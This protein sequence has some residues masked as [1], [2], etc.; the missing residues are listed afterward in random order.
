VNSVEY[1][2]QRRS[3]LVVRPARRFDITACVL[4]NKDLTGETLAS[5][6][7]CFGFDLEQVERRAAAPDC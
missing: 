6:R 5:L 1:R 4:M 3:A 7:G 2:K